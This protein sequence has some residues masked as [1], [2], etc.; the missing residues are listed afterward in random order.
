MSSLV[1]APPGASRPG[2]VYHLGWWYVYSQGDQLDHLGLE[3]CHHPK[4]NR[5]ILEKN[6]FELNLSA[7][8]PLQK[9]GAVYPGALRAIYIYIYVTQAPVADTATNANF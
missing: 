8:A 6:S 2:D 9:G 7:F 1:D 4:R 5:S 3:T